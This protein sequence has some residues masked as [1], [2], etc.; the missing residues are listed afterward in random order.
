MSSNITLLLPEGFEIA[1]AFLQYGSA[2]DVS[3]QLELPLHEVVKTLQTPDVKRY[4]DGVYMDL[5]Y[6]NRDKLA[7]VIDKMID[8]KLAE[9]EESGIYSSKDLLEIITIAH[10]MRM[11]EI[12]AQKA[13]EA[14]TAQTTVQIANFGESNYGRLMERLFDGKTL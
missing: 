6:R 4:L 10:K 8:A 14:P 2:K 1:N 3:E 9:A 11:D 13:E 7:S 12:K 5:G